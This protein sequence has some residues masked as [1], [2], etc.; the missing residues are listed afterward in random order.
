MM[1]HQIEIL[2]AVCLILGLGPSV[3][4]F[5]VFPVWSTGNV[6][7]TPDVDNGTVVWS[8]LV[9]GDWDVYG[10]D[11]LDPSAPQPIDV[12]AYIDSD[13]TRPAIWDHTVAW[14]DN[15]LG[16]WDIWL[17]DITDA[18]DPLPYQISPYE[19]N[20]THPAIHGNT[21]VWQDEFDTDDWDIYAADVTDPTAPDVYLVQLT[22]KDH[23]YANQQAPCIYRHR[24]I[25]QDNWLGDWDVASADLWL[26]K[27]PLDQFIS[28]SSLQQEN[29]A[30]GGDW[31][32]WQEDFGDGDFDIYAADISDPASPVESALVENASSQINPDISG[33]LVVW[34]D[35]RN[36]N[37]DIYG[38]N[39]IT[40]EE[41]QITTDLADQTNPAISGS[42]VAWE[43]S[44]VTPVTIYYTWLDGD[45]IADC[46]NKLAGDIDGD[47]QVNLT[48]YVRMAQ[49]WLACA[50]EPATACTY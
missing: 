37:W 2:C 8:E 31:V 34:Q 9:E 22:D 15:E 36:G 10:F 6:Q 33:H 48:D 46:P 17:T 19:S 18:A 3:G 16:D 38:Y 11:L 12:A 20:Q 44:R 45:A 13:Q 7:E 32:V 50:L 29:P 35:N 1:K 5:E 43:D 42:L 25:W 4:A 40:R 47:C 41:F 21:V 49:N 23:Y 27:T 30:I 28:A 14:Q 26:K 24:L 39:L